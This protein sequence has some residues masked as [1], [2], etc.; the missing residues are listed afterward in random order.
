MRADAAVGADLIAQIGHE[1]AKVGEIGWCAAIQ[2]RIL[3]TGPKR[4]V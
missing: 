1:A 4:N 2:N 3:P